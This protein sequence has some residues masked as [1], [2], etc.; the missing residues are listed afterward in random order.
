MNTSD[1]INQRVLKVM[2]LKQL[3]RSAFVA[4]LETSLPVLTHISTGR[5]KPGLELIQKL[6]EKFP[7]VSPDWLLT[8]RGS[9][10]RE[11]HV[12]PSLETELNQLNSLK[13]EIKTQIKAISQ[14]EQ[15]HR[16]L[17]KEINYLSEL[18]III[19]NNNQVSNQHLQ[20]LENI[21][22][23]IKQKMK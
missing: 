5:N 19:N 12:L 7:D 9:M 21:Q 17:L 13:A 6:I 11:L 3:S 15:Y 10:H 18:Q 1:T 22:L 16:I 20:D 23:S 14:I 2:A 4:I 8:G